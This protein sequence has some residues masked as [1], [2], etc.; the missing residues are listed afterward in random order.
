MTNTIFNYR[1]RF[2]T[3][4]ILTEIMSDLPMADA[5]GIYNTKTPKFG[6][7]VILD[8]M[9]WEDTEFGKGPLKSCETIRFKTGERP[10]KVAKEKKATAK[11]VSTKTSPT[12]SRNQQK[13][14]QRG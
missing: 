3:K 6:S 7:C 1:L 13:K 4:G 14:F 12:R 5:M 2:I 9:A 8:E 10:A 11:K